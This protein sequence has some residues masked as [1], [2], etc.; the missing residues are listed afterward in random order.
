MSKVSGFCKR[1][2]FSNVRNHGLGVIIS[3]PA[4]GLQAKVTCVMGVARATRL[5]LS[6]G[7][8]I[9]QV[10]LLADGA[11]ASKRECLE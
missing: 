4:F 10:L 5:T 11:S 6:T 2:P 9:G 7:L 3:G 8:A 1:D